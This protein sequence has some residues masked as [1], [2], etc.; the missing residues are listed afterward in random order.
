MKI[1][2][3]PLKGTTQ[4]IGNIK[5]LIRIVYLN[6]LIQWPL[7]TIAIILGVI[8]VKYG[9]KFA[10]PL[11]I[12]VAIAFMLYAVKHKETIIAYKNEIDRKK[13]II[14]GEYKDQQEKDPQEE[15]T[16]STE[17]A[18]ERKEQHPIENEKSE[19]I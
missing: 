8:H 12:T 10:I 1:S 2:L 3:N 14:M 11:A 6:A 13:E 16:E 18:E 9:A 4:T 15:K 5:P 17:K 7:F 19:P